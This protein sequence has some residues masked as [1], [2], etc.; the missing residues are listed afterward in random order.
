MARVEVEYKGVKGILIDGYFPSSFSY[1]KDIDWKTAGEEKFQ[2]SDEV[3]HELKENIYHRFMTPG[4]KEPK[5]KPRSNLY[6]KIKGMLEDKFC[7]Y[8]KE[9][10]VQFQ[11]PA[12]GAKTL[13]RIISRGTRGRKDIKENMIP[14]FNREIDR[15]IGAGK[16]TYVFQLVYLDQNPGNY[17]PSFEECAS[18]WVKFMGFEIKKEEEYEDFEAFKD[19][20]EMLL[21]RDIEGNVPHAGWFEK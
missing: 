5:A 11:F 6:R 4:A 12:I 8:N 3:Q 1:F 7:Q 13:R 15:D 18:N 2:Q 16:D 9:P 17:C 14:V 20:A 21:K 19:A 10:C